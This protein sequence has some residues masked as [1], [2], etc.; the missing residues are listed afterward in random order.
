MNVRSTLLVALL[1]LGCSSEPPKTDADYKREITAAMHRSLLTDLDA[2]ITSA[3]ELQAA[4]PAP[5]GRGWN[6][7]DVTAIESMQKSWL[8]ARRAYEHVEGALAPIFPDLDRSLDARYENFLEGLVGKGDDYLFDDAG[9]TGM[10]AAERILFLKST[11]ENVLTFEQSLPGY[12]AAAWPATEAEAAD[13]KGKLLHKIV[14]DAQTIRAGWE[15]AK[16]D[17]GTAWQGLVGLMNEQKEKVDK[18]S[19]GTEE[20]RY[21]QRTMNDIRWN[22]EGTR[23]VYALF[24]PWLRSKPGGAGIDDAI[25]RGFG[26]LQ[27]VYDAVSGEAIPA[28]PATWSAEKPTEADLATPF[29]K[30]WSGVHGSVDPAQKASIVAQMN[31]ASV[32]FGFPVL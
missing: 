12:K 17:I 7:G 4:A 18:A 19:E 24:S 32:L 27:G 31:E 2:L 16:I 14:V 20:S 26:Q 23:K 5:K 9:V 30:L 21:A 1:T 10:H 3:N 6:D 28:P 13:F 8:G 29:G 25:A 11:P 22:L 15:P